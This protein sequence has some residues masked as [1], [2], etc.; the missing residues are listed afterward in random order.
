MSVLKVG[1]LVK[2]CGSLYHLGIVLKIEDSIGAVFVS[3]QKYGDKI[4]W[5]SAECDVISG[6]G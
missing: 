1:D 5:L 2:Y 3:R 6:H 4:W